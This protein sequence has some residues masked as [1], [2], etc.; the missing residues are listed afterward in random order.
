MKS[1]SKSYNLILRKNTTLWIEIAYEMKLTWYYIAIIKK[2]EKIEK[3]S[4]R[5]LEKKWKIN[6]KIKNC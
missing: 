6:S 5:N 3:N 2:I 4:K 1:M